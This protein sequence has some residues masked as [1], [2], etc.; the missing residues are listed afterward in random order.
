MK[1]EIYNEI[2]FRNKKKKQT[3]KNKKA[4]RKKSKTE[5]AKK[6]CF[7]LSNNEQ[8][9]SCNFSPSYGFIK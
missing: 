9:P 2:L 6:K 5:K 3:N 8:F 4:K 7:P 1:V